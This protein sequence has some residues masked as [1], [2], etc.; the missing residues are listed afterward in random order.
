M[1][2]KIILYGAVAVIIAVI[3][4]FAVLPG[5][6]MIKNFI[7]QGPNVPTSMTAVSTQIKPLSIQYNGTSVVSSDQRNATLQT[8]FYVTNPNNTTI[9]LESINYVIYYGPTVIGHGEIGQGYED[10]WQ[11]SYYFPLVAGTSSNIQDNAVIVNTG[12]YPDIWSAIQKGTSKITVSGTA[13]YAVKTAFSG[14]D[15]TTDFNFTKS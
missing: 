12:N 10:N 7:P 6:G 8:N 9:I 15:Y 1:D 3:I 11:S 14:S 2:A 5:S 13:Y 4:G